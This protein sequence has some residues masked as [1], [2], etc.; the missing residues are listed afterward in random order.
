MNTWF[1]LNRAPTRDLPH[2]R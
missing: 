2:W 1:D